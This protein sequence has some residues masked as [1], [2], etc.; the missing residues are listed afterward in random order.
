MTL[1][2]LTYRTIGEPQKL[3]NL[4]QI[5]FSIQ[6]VDAKQTKQFLGI[7]LNDRSESSYNRKKSFEIIAQLTFLN[8]I[9][10]E[11]TIDKLLDIDPTDDLFIVVQAIKFSYHFYGRQEDGILEW[12]TTL[13]LHSNPEI[14]SESFYALGR[15]YFL[16][17]I[18]QANMADFSSQLILSKE[19]FVK[20]HKE[21]ENR[22]DAA[23]FLTLCSFFLQVIAPER[24][25]LGSLYEAV[26]TNL[27]LYVLNSL[28]TTRLPIYIN[29]VDC[30]S[31]IYNIATSQPDNWLDFRKEFNEFSIEMRKIDALGICN[32]FIVGST[33][34]R[35]IGPINEHL[36]S[37]ILIKK[38]QLEIKKLRTLYN[39]PS[40]NEQ[41]KELINRIVQ[42]IDQD[43]AY[44]KKDVFIDPEI[45]AKIHSAF[46]YIPIE[47]IKSDLINLENDN[48]SAIT[49]LYVYYS[50]ASG[51][52]RNEVF[53]T[54]YSQ[55]DEIIDLISKEINE[56]LPAYPLEK[57][58]EFGCV[59]RDVVNYFINCVRG[60]KGRFGFLFKP[61]ALEVELQQSMLTHLEAGPR[62]SLYLSEVKEFA[63]GGRVDIVYNSNKIQLPIEL[64]RD[65]EALTWEAITNKYIGQ[66][67]SYSYSRDQISFFLLLDLSPQNSNRPESDIRNLFK[68]I[69]LQPRQISGSKFSN[70][71][72]AFIVPGNKITPSERSR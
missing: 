63:D 37:N 55:G 61:N 32:D 9:G 8:R 15:I 50:N 59:L 16:L 2:Y 14:R 13:S 7:L 65:F 67:Q 42:L 30:T 70:Y 10:I 58:S 22:I 31:Y 23:L 18:S 19:Y 52:I 28:N 41:Q 17:A 43:F 48:L 33:S 64:K 4:L 56:L 46:P 1:D 71:V 26:N 51:K 69:T 34:E 12:L 47:K 49:D 54:G 35:H 68:V 72:I 39:D 21:V 27:R 38:F 57:Y 60:D 66:V 53:T 62:A 44:K 25:N 11:G 40:T 24:K 3:E 29:L 45:L 6:H 36:L 20:S 5:E